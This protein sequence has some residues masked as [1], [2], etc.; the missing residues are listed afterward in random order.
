MTRDPGEPPSAPSPKEIHRED[1]R[2]EQVEVLVEKLRWLR[3]PGMAAALKDLLARAAA[4]NLTVSA[5]VSQLCDEEKHSR[6]RSSVDRRIKDARFPEVNTVDAFDFDFDPVRKKLRARYLALHD[7]AFLDKGINPLFIGS[8]GTGKTFLARALAYRAC[9]AQKRVVFTSAPRMLTDSHGAEVHG[10]LDRALRRYVRAD[11]SPSTTSPSSRWTPPRPSSP[12]RSSPSA[13]TTA[14]RP[15]SPPTVPSR[16]GRRSSPT[17]STPRSSPSASPSGPR[18]SSSTERA[19]GRTE[20]DRLRLLG[21]EPSA[22]PAVHA[23]GEAP[24]LPPRGRVRRRTVSAPPGGSLDTGDS[25]ESGT[26]GD[27]WRHFQQSPTRGDDLLGR[28]RALDVANAGLGDI[29]LGLVALLVFAPIG[30]GLYVR[31]AQVSMTRVR[32]VR[33]PP[34]GALTSRTARLPPT[35]TRAGEVSS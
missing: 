22:P 4:E 25:G 27:R 28:D 26:P 3:L 7:L 18:P 15:A 30:T 10:S 8:P 13:T 20:P 17:R 19:T 5:V 23:D 35:L 14:A 16:T 9:Q 12:S 2:R 32:P 34:T 1:R 6:I 31:R 29:L 21:Q 24:A 33:L 11:L